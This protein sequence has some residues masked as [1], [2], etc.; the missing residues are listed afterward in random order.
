MKKFLLAQ[1]AFLAFFTA[2]SDDCDCDCC[3]TSSKLA[4]DEEEETSSSSVCVEDESSSS[5][6]TELSV[7]CLKGTWAFS[8]FGDVSS[9]YAEANTLTLTSCSKFTYTPSS[10]DSDHTYC[11]GYTLSGTYELSGEDKIVFH[12]GKD[13]STTLA[14]L[15]FLDSVGVVSLSDSGYTLSITGT[16]GY[17]LFVPNDEGGITEVYTKE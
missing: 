14:G 5:A 1:L 10:D 9:D 6:C 12:A 2:C 8:H 13:G 16:G 11:V 17:S 3:N 7:D 4:E 15:C